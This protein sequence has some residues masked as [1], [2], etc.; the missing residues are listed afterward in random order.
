[1]KDEKR[2]NMTL[3]GDYTQVGEIIVKDGD[4]TRLGHIVAMRLDG[5]PTDEWYIIFSSNGLIV[6]F[7]HPDGWRAKTYTLNGQVLTEE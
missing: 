3:V 4:F 1:M 5:Y 6:P 2:Y 7:P